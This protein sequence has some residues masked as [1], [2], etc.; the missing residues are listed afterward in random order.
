M[1]ISIDF[2]R[3]LGHLR[4]NEKKKPGQ[5]SLSGQIQATLRELS[6]RRKHFGDEEVALEDEF[7]TD[8]TGDGVDLDTFFESERRDID[9]D[10]GG[11]VFGE[12]GDDDV[13]RGGAEFTPEPDASGFPIETKW[14][15]DG[16]F[17]VGI[18]GI[19]IGVEDA[20]RNRIA[21]N[22]FHH[23]V[24]ANFF[25]IIIDDERE[26]DVWTEFGRENFLEVDRIDRRGDGIDMTTVANDRDATGG[27]KFTAYAF[28]TTD[29][30]RTFEL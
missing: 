28:F 18:D 27:A 9:D 7:A 20:A 8:G 15:A 11:N 6:A 4:G 29:T 24:T 2:R 3:I 25:T 21:L 12:A 23:D 10:I 17:A 22:A 5:A 16:D 14:N 19:E 30:N 1:I 13:T 26:D